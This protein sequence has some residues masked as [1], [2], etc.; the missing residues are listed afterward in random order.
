MVE[1]AFDAPAE[2]EMESLLIEKSP[3]EFSEAYK[4]LTADFYTKW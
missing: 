4:Q 2:P 1:F 3:G